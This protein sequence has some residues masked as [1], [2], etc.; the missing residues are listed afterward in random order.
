M[1]CPSQLLYFLRSFYVPTAY[2][3]TLLALA[4]NTCTLLLLIK[5]CI[6]YGSFHRTHILELFTV[7]LDYIIQLL[8]LSV[9]TFVQKA[10]L[11]SSHPVSIFFHSSSHLAYTFCGCNRMFF[12]LSY[13]S[14]HEDYTILC[15]NIIGNICCHDH[16]NPDLEHILPVVS[17]A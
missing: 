12:L 6:G 17:S 10:S 5:F 7:L 8:Q 14:Y 11:C 4:P 9:L 3:F 15:A 2:R 13:T 1:D 16:P